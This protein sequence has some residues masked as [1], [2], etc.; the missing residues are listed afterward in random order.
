MKKYADV[1]LDKH[2]GD[3]SGFT[4]EADV[5]DTFYSEWLKDS[6]E[7]HY[8][9]CSEKNENA[10]GYTS[11]GYHEQE[12]FADEAKAKIRDILAEKVD[13]ANMDKNLQAVKMKPE[14]PATAQAQRGKAEFATEQ[15]AAPRKSKRKKT[16]KLGR[17]DLCPCGSGKKY[18][19]CC[20]E[21][22]I[23]Y[24]YIKGKFV[25]VS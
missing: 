24:T 13:V 6:L 25:T 7:S 23:E 9:W 22:G 4:S 16:T 5:I 18:K 11:K 19:K 1:F 2:K 14:P 3:F 12:G 17:N 20:L 8:A 15:K 10:A 21:K